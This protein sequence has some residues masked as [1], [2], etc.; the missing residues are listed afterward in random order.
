[1]KFLEIPELDV[2]SRALST[3]N[4][5]IKVNAR[6]EAYSCKA[7][8]RE[9][10]LFKT[11]ES[12]LIQDISHSTSVSPPEHHQGLLESA[13]GPLDKRESRKTLWMLIGLLNVAFPDHDFSKVRPEDFRREDGPRAVLSSLSAALDHLRSPSGQRSFSTLPPLPSSSSP[14][15]EPIGLPGTSSSGA[16][17]VTGSTMT[18]TVDGEVPTNPFLRQVLDPII[19]LAECEVFSYTPDMDSDPHAVDSDD[20]SDDDG[21]DPD[22][23]EREDD[24]GMAWEME[25]VEAMSG[26]RTRSSNHQPHHV[27]GHHSSSRGG[28]TSFGGGGSRGGNTM[29]VGS[30]HNRPTTP[31]KSFASFFGGINSA[32]GTPAS[33]VD[34]E[35][36]FGDS[37]SSGGLLWSTFHFLYNRKAKRI[38]FITAWARTP[39]V[40]HRHH[41][42]NRLGS[43]NK[44]GKTMTTST[45]NS[46]HGSRGVSSSRRGVMRRSHSRGSTARAST[47]GAGQSDESDILSIEGDDDDDDDDDD[48]G[49]QGLSH[50]FD[51]PGGGG[52]GGV[53]NS[54]V[55]HRTTTSSSSTTAA[56]APPQVVRAVAKAAQAQS[57]MKR[58]LSNTS[59][60]VASTK[61]TKPTVG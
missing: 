2:L 9:R 22:A 16:T 51:G 27:L 34:S 31:M 60:Q 14:Y 5:T 61:K 13:F 58:S 41:V 35:E 3:S 23:F 44:F 15:S 37:Y 18:T 30:W 45:M 26:Y 33:V 54:V 24:G 40:D 59:I 57:H 56:R 48:D 4:P 25:G 47:L 19:D 10:K 55:G 50:H 7:V 32:P 21:G 42:H 53:V 43:D 52:G 28:T 11:L 39:S 8:A 6:V 17:A 46:R 36:Y 20:E 1:M 29:T 12:E 38:V 49:D